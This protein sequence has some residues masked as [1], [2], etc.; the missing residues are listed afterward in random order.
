[1]AHKGGDAA[2][3]SIIANSGVAVTLGK[4]PAAAFTRN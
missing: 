4:T 1:V 2:D 3:A